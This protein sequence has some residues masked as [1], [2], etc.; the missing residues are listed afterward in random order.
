M[1]QVR[2]QGVANIRAK[3]LTRPVGRMAHV[4][5]VR[6]APIL[7]AVRAASQHLRQQSRA[8][9]ACFEDDLEARLAIHLVQVRH[10]IQV[11]TTNL[12]EGSFVEERQRTRW[13][14]GSMRRSRR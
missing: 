9:V 11:R 4:H 3:L 2:F 12:A 10:R 6:D 14:T 1:S 13:S 5:A 8:A 7:D